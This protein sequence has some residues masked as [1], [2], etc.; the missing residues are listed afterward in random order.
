MKIPNFP[1]HLG[2]LKGRCQRRLYNGMLPFLG[3]EPALGSEPLDV[4]IYSFCCE[5]DLAEQSA[6]IRSFLKYVGTPKSFTVVSDGSLTESARAHLHNIHD[7]VRTAIWS[8]LISAPLPKPVA[9]FAARN[10]MGKKLAVEINMPVDGP[11]IYL[12][13]DI[14]FFRGGRDLRNVILGDR[15]F[16][17]YL[18]DCNV[19]L[20]RRMLRNEDEA[21]TPVNAGF[22]ILFR[23]PDWQ[24]ALERF[25]QLTDPIGNSEQTVI[26]LSLHANSAVMLDPSKYILKLDDQTIFSDSYFSQSIVLRHY[27]NPVRHKFWSFMF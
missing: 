8:E 4:A 25:G 7:S 9:D 10:P 3:R 5:R 1:Y 19:S 14:L 24:P 17:R 27:V 20:D 2:I 23:Q 15:Q 18:L 6:S 26:H 22:Y 16:P 21:K 11:T 13:S 12:D